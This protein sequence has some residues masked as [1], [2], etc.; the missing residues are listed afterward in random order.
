MTQRDGA[1]TLKPFTADAASRTRDVLFVQGA[2]DGTHDDWDAKLVASLSQALGSGFEVAYPAM[3]AEDDPTYATWR[4]VIRAE[5]TRLRDGVIAV[6]H[7]VGGTILIH[8]L[9]DGEVDRAL[10]GIVLIASPFLGAGGWPGDEFELASDLG[11][12]LPGGVPVDL[13]HGLDDVDVPPAHVDL[14]GTAI[15]QA[16]VHRLPGRD[17]QL[18]ND[19]TD[20]ANVIRGRASG[21]ALPIAGANDG[22]NGAST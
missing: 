13:F 20:V 16:R 15:P 3:P 5:L 19:L 6:G 1:G 18:G 17:H 14:Y 2:G 10:G 21:D 4:P 22:T 9:T 12:R 7:S 8:A 11:A